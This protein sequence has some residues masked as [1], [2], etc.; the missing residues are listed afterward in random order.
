MADKI[1]SFEDLGVWQKAHQMVLNVYR[2]TGS[3]PAE[4]RFGLTSQMR[5]G[6]GTWDMGTLPRL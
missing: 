4:E 2:I 3:F 6:R 1:T 5:R